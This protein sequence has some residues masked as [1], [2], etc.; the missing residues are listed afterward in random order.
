[1]SHLASPAAPSMNLRLSLVPDLSPDVLEVITRLVRGHGVLAMPTESYYALGASPFDARAVQRVCD[2][3]GRSQDNP[4]LVLIGDRRQ[5]TGLVADV[6]PAAE[7]LMQ[8]FWPGPLTLVLPAVSHLPRVLTAG[9]G[10]VGVRLSSHPILIRLLQHVGPLTG[11]SANR[12][13]RPAVC[14]AAQVE[15]DLGRDVDA[16]LDGEDTPGGAPSTVVDATGPIRLLREG[17]IGRQAIRDLLGA[18]G[19]PC[20]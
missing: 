4:I 14:S 10:T 13:G 16:I 7:A 17:L 12:T 5:L 8:H 9:T 15:A 11:T 3:K 1:M 19:F 6:P 2:I 20:A 18:R